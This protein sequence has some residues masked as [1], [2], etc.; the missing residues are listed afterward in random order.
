M[1]I[2]EVKTK[3]HEEEFLEMPRLIYK[4]DP[5]WI[6]HIRQDIQKIFDPEK[7]K[8]FRYGEATRFIL[9]DD[10]GKTIGRV[11]AFINRRLSDTFK[12]P[13]GGFGFF[14]CIDDAAAAKMLFDK[15]AE[16]NAERGM[17]A[18]DGPINFGEKDQFWGLM[19]TNFESPATYGMNYN[20][21]YYRKFFDDYGFKTYYEQYCYYRNAWQPAQEIFIRKSANL[22]K[23][24]YHCKILN[25][26]Q[27]EKF[28]EDF[29]TIYNSAWGG[30]SG[31][32]PMEKAQALNIMQKLKPVLDPDIAVFAYHN[33]TP[34]G[35]YISIPELNK[36][37]K[38]VNGN[39]N[40]WGK[41]KFMYHKLKG[42]CRT[43]Y[44]IVFGVA[45]QHQGKGVEGFMIKFLEEHIY[46][47][48]KYDDIVLTW[49]GDFNPKM[50]KVIE[51]LECE[52]WRTYITCRKM[53]DESIPF[54]RAPIIE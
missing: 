48:D 17:K 26:K 28:A 54:E 2:I 40:W 9:K 10:N 44:S 5:N 27:T 24:G 14:E 51:N 25:P 19:I 53:L 30:H 4:N 6:P 39:L 50:L 1:Q 47:L 8:F 35:F 11:A 15:C 12:Q 36:L 49:I 38:Y 21:P 18:I 41:I 33:E 3:Q 32:K 23:E 45:K 29:R 20:P 42:D 34:V 37:F 13:T 52:K 16:W 22:K 31:F 7:N 46:P 43:I